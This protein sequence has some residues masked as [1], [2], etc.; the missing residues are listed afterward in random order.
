MRKLP[1][2]LYICLLAPSLLSQTTDSPSH[3]PRSGYVPDADTAIKIGEA[4]LIPVYG[5]NQIDSEQP[6]TAT[7]TGNSIWVVTGT[8]HCKGAGSC[9]GGVATVSITKDDGRVL[10]MTHGK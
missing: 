3:K 8:L 6:F 9:D 10:S 2:L 5:A 7:L 4:V 1:I